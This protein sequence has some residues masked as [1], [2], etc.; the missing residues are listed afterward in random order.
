MTE[1]PIVRTRELRKTYGLGTAHEIEVL[2]VKD[3]RFKFHPI[4]DWTDIDVGAYMLLHDLPEH[5]LVQQ[6][7][8]SVGD[9]HTTAPLR[10]GMDAAQT[11]FFGLRRE[12]GLHFDESASSAA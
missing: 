10:P 4:A 2:Q 1:Q 11:R 9:V 7:Y 12:C 8:V 3:G 5:P 6:G